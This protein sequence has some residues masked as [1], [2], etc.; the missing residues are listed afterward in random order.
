M[1]GYTP[2]SLAA[3]AKYVDGHPLK[4]SHYLPVKR[5]PKVQAGPK[6]EAHLQEVGGTGTAHLQEVDDTDGASDEEGDGLNTAESCAQ[7]MGTSASAH[8]NWLKDAEVALKEP[9]AAEKDAIAETCMAA[10]TVAIAKLTAKIDYDMT[11]RDYQTTQGLNSLQFQVA[12]VTDGL[13][14]IHDAAR[15]SEST[16]AARHKEQVAELKDTLMQ[17][18]ALTSEDHDKHVKHVD[19]TIHQF[20]RRQEEQQSSLSAQVAEQIDSMHGTMQHSIQNEV[21]SFIGSLLTHTGSL[22]ASG[23]RA[24]HGGGDKSAIGTAVTTHTEDSGAGPMGE[25]DL[26]AYVVFDATRGSE[27]EGTPQLTI[28]VSLLQHVV[29][30]RYGCETGDAG[31]VQRRSTRIDYCYFLR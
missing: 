8:E 10:T 16:A 12:A 25:R 19:A 15:I 4:F 2:M 7:A 22:G 11:T 23:S 28:P 5:A 18:S 21:P 13:R 9:F 31:G 17:F 29:H 3:R 6:A 1:P 27:L 26:V 24:P 14:R 30:T 20:M